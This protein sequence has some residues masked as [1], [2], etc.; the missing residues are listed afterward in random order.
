M[1]DERIMAE[2]PIDTRYEVK[3]YAHADKVQYFVQ[4]GTNGSCINE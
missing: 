1:L 2:N 4:E 3:C